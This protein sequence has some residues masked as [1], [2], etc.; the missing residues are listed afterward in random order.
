[1][2]LNSL[3]PFF[4]FLLVLFGVACTPKS[5]PIDYGSDV[6][7]YCKMTI[8]DK[9]HGAEA[10][11][12]KGKVYKFDAV[13]CLSWFENEN[14]EL[15]YAFELVNNF[16]APGELINAQESTFLISKAVPSPMGAFL[17]AFNSEEEAKK[18]QSNKGGDLFSW[19]EIKKQIRK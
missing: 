14:S 17:S 10:V 8:V 4:F 6:C 13:E 18:L 1:M 3:I 9:Q 12:S 16:M 15:E 7:H 5:R 11:T 2:R 19:E